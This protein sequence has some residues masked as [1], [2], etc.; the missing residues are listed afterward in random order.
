M[1]CLVVQ[2]EGVPASLGFMFTCQLPP[3]TS[4]RYRG[5][6]GVDACDSLASAVYA[7][8]FN[9]L[10]RRMAVCGKPDLEDRYVLGIV[11]MFSLDSQIRVSRRHTSVIPT[12]SDTP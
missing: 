10:V 5:Q 3:K 4:Y 11:D 12:D 7:L 6:P 1:C 9:V 8:L 2:E